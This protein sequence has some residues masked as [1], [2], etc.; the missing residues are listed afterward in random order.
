MIW[1]VPGTRKVSSI[2]GIIQ[3]RDLL[4]HGQAL[5]QGVVAT[6]LDT[7]ADQV[8]GHYRRSVLPSIPAGRI[9]FTD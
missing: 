3:R 8:I 6:Q 9:Y 7:V 5:R 1:A 4:V 2:P